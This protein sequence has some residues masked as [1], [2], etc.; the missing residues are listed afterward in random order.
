MNAFVSRLSRALAAGT[1]L[2]C[3]ATASAHADIITNGGFETG[4]FTGWTGTFQVGNTVVVGPAS[5]HGYTPHT[6]QHFVAFGDLGD[7]TF[8]QSVTETAGQDY[9]LTYFLASKGDTL[10]SFSASWDGATLQGS[11]VT[12]P[13]SGL[14]YVEYSFTVTGTGT[15]TLTFH[16]H[17]LPSFLALDDV[18]LIPAA[19]PGPI[20]GAGLPGLIFAAGGLLGWWR[21]KRKAATVAS[22]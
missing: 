20:V 3:C 17:D 9:I 13:N 16:E 15:D 14:A 8:S 1:V 22:T 12:D 6:G 21:R 2:V 18:S 5:F 19:V 7:S 4:D 11:Q 10:T